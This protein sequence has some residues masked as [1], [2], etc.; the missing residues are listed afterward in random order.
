MPDVEPE[1]PAQATAKALPV[2]PWPHTAALLYVLA[3]WSVYGLLHLRVTLMEPREMTY[4]SHIIVECLL[5]GSTIAGIYHRRAFLREVFGKAGVRVA[6]LDI[7]GGVL[8]YLA[9]ITAMVVIGAVLQ[10]LHP[11]YRK[12]AVLAMAPHSSA[13]LA[14][15][16]G[17]SLAAGVCEEMLFRGYLLRQLAGWWGSTLAAIAA[18]SLLFGC[19]HLYEGWGAMVGLCGLGAVYAAVAVLRGNLRSVMVAH[20]LQDAVT[21]LVLF[22]RHGS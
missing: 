10:P 2:A 13:E 16:L 6:A 21:G 7:G 22:L 4:V 15:W 1:P 8:V 18:S 3:L 20:F 17:V 14:L 9:G 5:A 19:L 12:E 11:D